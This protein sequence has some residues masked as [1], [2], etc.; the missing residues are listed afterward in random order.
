MFSEQVTS[1][2]E[3]CQELSTFF[4]LLMDNIKKTACTAASP[5]GVSSAN[6]LSCQLL[7]ISNVPVLP[8]ITVSPLSCSPVPA[9]SVFPAPIPRSTAVGNLLS[10]SFTSGKARL[11]RQVEAEAIAFWNEFREA[12]VYMVMDGWR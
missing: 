10:F 11:E 5:S 6:I 9:L 2:S 4:V 3:Y 8:L 1:T 12:A 7:P